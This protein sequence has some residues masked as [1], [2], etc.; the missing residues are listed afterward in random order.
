MDPNTEQLTE[1]QIASKISSAVFAGDMDALDV[2]MKA[3]AAPVEEAAPAEAVEEPPVG[4]GATPDD[5]VPPAAST[6]NAEVS[7]PAQI[8]STPA[9]ENSL[10]KEEIARLRRVEQAYKSDEGRTPGL[11]RR[12]AKAEEELERLRQ[13]GTNVS[14]PNQPSAQSKTRAQERIAQLKETDPFM[15]E[16]ME[17]ALNELRVEVQGAKKEAE[18][19]LSER[20]GDEALAREADKLRAFHPQAFQ[21]FEMPEWENWKSVQTPG[22]RALA[23][24]MYADDVIKA[25]QYFY[26]DLSPRWNPP[27]PSA[28]SVPSVAA[29]V[30]VVD[31]PKAAK[32]SIERQRKLEASNLGSSPVALE[33]DGLPTDDSKLHDYYYKSILK[34]MGVIKK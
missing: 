11:Q 3:E 25:F 29:P 4:V 20:D 30:A 10:L 7:P 15:A 34:N 1:D 17:D 33:G 6:T 21:V 23:E 28:P 8:A 5:S 27:A 19:L 13:A 22:V 9:D 26:N 14:Q 24:S 12:L 18:R 32:V 16:L 31:D 2:L